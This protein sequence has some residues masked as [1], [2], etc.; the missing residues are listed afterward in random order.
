MSKQSGFTTSHV[1]DCLEDFLVLHKHVNLATFSFEDMF[2][3]HVGTFT[4]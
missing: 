2:V 4:F 1:D 3:A